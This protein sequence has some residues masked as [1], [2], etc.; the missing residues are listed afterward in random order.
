[1]V[2]M[3]WA[4]FL[5]RKKFPGRTV[6]WGLG[7]QL[8]LALLILV[9]PWGGKIFEFAGKGVR[10][11]GG[12]GLMGLARKFR[13]AKGRRLDWNANEVCRNAF[14]APERG[15]FNAQQSQDD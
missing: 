6:V 5:N 2:L 7:A 9:A 3:A 10:S 8:A 12:A 14:T 15:C 11:V 13:I 4:I 1:M